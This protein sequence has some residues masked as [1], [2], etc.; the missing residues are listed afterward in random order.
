LR[1]HSAEES[2]ASPEEIADQIDPE[3]HPQAKRKIISLT[4]SRIFTARTSHT[5]GTTKEHRKDIAEAAVTV[6]H[7]RRTEC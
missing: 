2:D 3:D 7:A 1:G 6:Y 4:I 5:S